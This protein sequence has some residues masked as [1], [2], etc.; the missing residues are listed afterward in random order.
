MSGFLGIGGSSAKTDRGW[1]LQSASGL[2]NLFNW[3]LPQAKTATAG[4]L[5]D[6]SSAGGFWKQLMSGNRSAVNAAVAPQA[7]TAQTMDD[8]SRRQA[9]ASGTARGGGVAGANQTQK[10]A[11]LARIQNM[12][13]GARTTGAEQLAKV[14]TAGAGIGSNIM[15]DAGNAAAN[16]GSLGTSARGQQLAQDN[17]TGAAVGQIAAGLLFA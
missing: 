4:G 5:S 16:L 15:A 12:L 6:L 7:N 2:S 1:Q 13:F 10:D 8:A 14:G 11:T 9:G 17:A 3:A